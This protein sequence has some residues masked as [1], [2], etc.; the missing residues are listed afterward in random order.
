MLGAYDRD[1]SPINLVYTCSLNAL[2]QSQ[3]FGVR[4]ARPLS[5]SK[6]WRSVTNIPAIDASYVSLHGRL[7]AIGGRD[8]GNKPITAVHMYDPST[9]SW[10]VVS[11]M[12]TPRSKC[13]ATV[14]PDN[15][16]IV[17]GGY[18]DIGGTKTD[19]VEIATSYFE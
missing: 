5:L 18:T 17:V 1:N 16:L 14:L 19:S 3:S 13:Y 11:H 7:L 8:S 2:L 9:N 6:V 15:Q 12:T 10:E 4:T